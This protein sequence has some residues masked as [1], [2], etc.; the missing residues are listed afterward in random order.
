MQLLGKQPHGGFTLLRPHGKP[1]SLT[2][3]ERSD[4]SHLS[5]SWSGIGASS[6]WP[7]ILSTEIRTH[8]LPNEQS[9]FIQSKSIAPIGNTLSELAAGFISEGTQEPTLLYGPSF[10]GSWLL[11][12]R[13]EWLST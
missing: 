2:R 12:A 4:F 1:G 10:R 6:S 5:R 11:G 3:K 13:F 9:N 8:I 7:L